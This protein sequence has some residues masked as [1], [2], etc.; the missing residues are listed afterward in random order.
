[1]K[2]FCVA[3]LIFLTVSVF[4]EEQKDST[5][6][7]LEESLAPIKEAGKNALGIIGNAIGEAGDF[8]GEKARSFSAKACIGTW[9]FKNGKAE[10]TITC[11]EDATMTVM[12]TSR[13]TEHVW[14]GSFS[15][16]P[17]SI[18]FRA[19]TKNSKTWFTRST[20]Q[21]DETWEI[22]FRAGSNE[23][24]V[25][26]ASIPKDSNGYDFLQPTIFVREGSAE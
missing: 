25:T 16:T 14:R 1:M 2:K 4:A 24:R 20:E 21:I 7:S 5:S 6:Q 9:K 15:S 23:L 22:S 12:Q 10:T 11:K 19:M 8:F 18:S 26:S 13:G 17:R 3:F